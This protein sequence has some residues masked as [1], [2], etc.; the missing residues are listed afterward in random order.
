MV[1]V[2]DAPVHAA[3]TQRVGAV[4]ELSDNQ[5]KAALGPCQ[6]VIECNAYG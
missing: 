5:N 6:G 2:G 4:K 1:G 3:Q